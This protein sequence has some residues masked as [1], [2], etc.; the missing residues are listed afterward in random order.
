MGNNFN[1]MYQN[2]YVKDVTNG[3]TGCETMQPL[4][5]LLVWKVT[6]TQHLENPL[7]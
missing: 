3:T 1:K 6:E 4:L 5:L 7:F 2:I